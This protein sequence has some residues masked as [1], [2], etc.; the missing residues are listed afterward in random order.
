MYY[1]KLTVRKLIVFCFLLLVTSLWPVSVFAQADW[2]ISQ[3]QSDIDIRPDGH[4]KVLEDIEVDFSVEKH[5]IFRDIPY[6]YNS[7]QGSVYTTVSQIIVTQDDLS[8]KYTVEKSDSY[9]R[10]KIGDANATIS[11]KHTYRLSY[12]VTGVIK[13]YNDHDE[14][15]WNATGDKWEVPIEKA[16]ATVTIPKERVKNVTCYQ[17]IAG[18]TQ[19]CASSID[20][21]T[22]A[23]FAS[24][25]L[26]PGQGMTEVVGFTKGIVPILTVEKPNPTVQYAGLILGFFIT[27]LL[28]SGYLFWQWWKNGRDPVEIATGSVPG[29]MPVNPNG[30]IV[31]EYEPP[32]KLRPAEIGVIMDER[33]D[34]LDITATI[35]DFAARGFLTITE[36]QK[37]WIFGS[38]DYTLKKTNKD[39]KEFLLYEKTLFDFLFESK[40][41]VKVSELKTEFYEKLKTVKDVL[42]KN[43]VTK[44]IFAKNPESVRTFY[45]ISGMIF[46]FCGGFGLLSAKGNFIL[47]GICTGMLGVGLLSL[48]FSRFMPRRTAYGH[49]LLY[50]SKGYELFISKAETFKQKYLEKQNLFNDI[51]PYAIVF[52]VTEK[53]AKA[54]QDM[55]IK[56]QQPS[57]YYSSTPFNP[58][59]FSNNINTFSSSMSSAISSVPRSSISGGSGFSGG[60]GGG[61]G[62]GG[63]GSW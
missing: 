52:G 20:S 63:G 13:S 16:S 31:V 2:E 7:P 59:M 10:V 56:P 40:D 30:S 41:S 38:T 61:F 48:L 32:Q 14:L 21:P 5:G 17:G 46:V 60:S 6:A 35:I 42:Y 47:L 23:S 62:G 36:E 15:Y 12:D 34:T 55:G 4:V 28:G 51:L 45:I 44:N 37:K 53:F 24:E 18:S 19:S 9:Y 29:Q 58:V 8:A 3:F 43:M 54:M 1:T 25:K 50:R 22:T 39:T 49:Q 57:W 26:S 27:F 11:G 33:A